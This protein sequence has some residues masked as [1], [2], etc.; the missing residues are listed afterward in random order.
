MPRY[1]NRIVTLKVEGEIYDNETTA[2]DIIKNYEW[3]CHPDLKNTNQYDIE[4]KHTNDNRGRI[5]HVTK[6]PEIHKYK[7]PDTEFFL[8]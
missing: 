5:T 8:V 7:K 4:I 6:L 2:E 3:K 1:F